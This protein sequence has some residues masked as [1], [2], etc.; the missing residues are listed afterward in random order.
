MNTPQYSSVYTQLAS[1]LR[2]VGMSVEAHGILEA[3]LRGEELGED[4]YFETI[5]GIIDTWDDREESAAEYAL[6]GLMKVG[7]AALRSRSP[8]LVPEVMGMLDAVHNTFLDDLE[9]EEEDLHGDVLPTFHA[10]YREL[11]FLPL[12]EDAGEERVEQVDRIIE[13]AIEKAANEAAEGKGA[14]EYVVL[15]LDYLRPQE[16]D[17]LDLNDLVAGI[18]SALRDFDDNEADREDAYKGPAYHA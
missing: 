13:Q 6:V 18:A 11:Q 5:T 17:T 2:V 7:A 3:Y 10:V 16:E 12:D 4:D 9:T 14:H 8:F 15:A 1:N